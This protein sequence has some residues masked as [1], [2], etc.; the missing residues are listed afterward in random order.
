MADTKRCPDCGEVK[1]LT[2]FPPQKKRRDGRH[3]YW[4]HHDHASG[5]V[6]GMLWFNCNQALGNVRDEIAVLRGL[7]DYLDD[8]HGRSSPLIPHQEI[9]F[10]GVEIDVD[11][12]G[13]WH[14]REPQHA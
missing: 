9:W 13:P 4:R 14:R 8:H 1:P 2:D 6:R 11:P 10:V 3:T 12:D 7:I 5:A